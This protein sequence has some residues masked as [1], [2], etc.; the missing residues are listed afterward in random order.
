MGPLTG[1]RIVEMG[2]IGPGPYAAM[3][4]ADLGA[5]ILRIERR[6]ALTPFPDPKY[7]VMLRGRR[8]VVLDLKKPEAVAAVLDLVGGADALIEGFRPGAMEAMGL[9]PDECLKR[10]PL[11]VYGRI[12]GW[13]QDGPL[14]GAA[15]H[16]INFI[17]LA[18]ALHAFGRQGG[19]PT[20]PLNL[21]GDF[22]GGGM[23]LAFGLVCALLEARQSGQGQ[24]VDAAMVDGAASQMALTH[25]FLQSGLWEDERG[26][27]LLD[28]GAHFYDTYETADEKWVAVGAIEPKFYAVLLERLGIDDPEVQYQFD[29]DRWP[30]LRA[31]LAAVFKQRTRDEWCEIME[32]ADACFAPVLSLGE[33]PD[34]PHNRARGTFVEVEGVTQPAP[35]PRFSRTPGAIQG[36]PPQSGE[37]TQSA[38][39]DWGLSDERLKSLSEAGAI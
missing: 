29:R 4:M 1:V 23:L 16:D 17:A 18:G 13:G 37:H 31:K 26:V 22:G 34:H 2:S 6:F 15:G 12:T 9:G 14:A 28:S 5:E 30:E 38:L 21:V 33:A 25:G 10:N 8:S 19:P 39:A 7:D 11:L 3:M 27:N 20:P 35:A 32:G 36:P 24:V